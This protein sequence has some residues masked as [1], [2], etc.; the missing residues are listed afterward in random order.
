MAGNSFGKIFVITTWGESHG[1]AVGVTID[2]CLPGME[3][4]EDDIQAELDRRRPGTGG[5]ASP[6]RNRTGSRSWPASS[7]AGPPAPRSA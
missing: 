2:G 4:S 5:A 6:A 1:T 3:L 7:K